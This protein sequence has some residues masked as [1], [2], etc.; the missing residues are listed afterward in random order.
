MVASVLNTKLLLTKMYK[1]V[2]KENVCLDHMS[3][4][5]MHLPVNHF[6]LMSK[7]HCAF[8]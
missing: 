3:T 7:I 5:L 6:L 1:L 4:D 2:P 8:T